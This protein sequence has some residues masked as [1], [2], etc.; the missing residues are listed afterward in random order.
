MGRVT[1]TLVVRILLSVSIGGP[2]EGVWAQGARSLRFEVTAP[3]GVWS[4]TM[5][6]RLIIVTAPAAGRQTPEPR[7]RIG[8]VGADASPIA[9]VDVDQLV[10]G[11]TV[12]VDDTSVAFPVER[13][14]DLP[15][16]EY[17]VQAVLDV[18]RSIRTPGAP[19]N[20]YSQPQRISVEPNRDLVVS[21]ALTEQVP[22]ERVPPD[23]EYLRYVHLPSERL[24][25]YHARP[26]I[27][28]AA[29]IL[30]RGFDQEPSRQY[31]M[32]LS[33]GG[34]GRRYTAAARL[35]RGGSPFRRAWLSDDAPRMLQVLLDGAGPHGDPY[36]VNS[37][38]NGLY[39]DALVDELIPYIEGR[40]RGLGVPGARVIDGIS[41]GGWVALALHVFYPDSFNGAWSYCPDAVDFRAL[42]RINIYDDDDAYVEDGGERPS[43][44]S[45]DGAI[46]F[47]MRHELRMENVLGRGDSWTESG[48]QWGAWN[49]VYGPRGDDGRPVPLWDPASGLIDRDLTSHWERYDLRL[50]LARNWA[51][52]APK[53]DGKLNIWIGEMDDYYLN[54]SVHLLDTFLRKRDPTFN[55][56]IA[57][58]PGEGHC[59][60]PHSPGEL[61]HEMGARVGAEP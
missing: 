46:R 57:Y 29:V 41:T 53:L 44:R 7:L 12:I 10:S 30:P 61:L 26:V 59:W 48:R 58:G 28:R 11:Q 22:P 19:G 31:P 25:T 52:L 27:L 36:Q 51:T 60:I 20:W 38:N 49:A 16:A 9:A 54:D 33:V 13:L 43:R 37:P 40:F 39:G 17:G 24:S 55:A 1:R 42:Q 50:V 4:I 23:T 18:S 8:S 14:S 35:M 56:R 3:T 6:G 2:A 21:L 34:Y 15:P 45:P 32:R 47:T 5:I